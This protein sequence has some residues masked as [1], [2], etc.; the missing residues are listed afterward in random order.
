MDILIDKKTNQGKKL[1]IVIHGVE[2]VTF[3][4]DVGA[5]LQV[6]EDMKPGK[7]IKPKDRSKYQ[8]YK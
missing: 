5:K 2:E 7:P 4:D 8:E 1:Y 6:Q 3:M